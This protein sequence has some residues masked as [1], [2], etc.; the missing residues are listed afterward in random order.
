MVS[1]SPLSDLHGRNPMPLRV[2]AYVAF[3]D[4]L[5]AR[6]PVTVASDFE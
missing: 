5:L 4:S 2:L 1:N 3:S 6:G